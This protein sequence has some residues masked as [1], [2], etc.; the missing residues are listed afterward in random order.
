MAEQVVIGGMVRRSLQ[1]GRAMAT[2][3][4]ITRKAVWDTLCDLEWQMRY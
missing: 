3:S 1:R 4:D 2:V